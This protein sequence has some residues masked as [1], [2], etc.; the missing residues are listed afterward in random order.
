MVS[1]DHDKIKAEPA[2]RLTEHLIEAQSKRSELQET[3]S[4]LQSELDKL[5]SQS[6]V[7]E[8]QLEELVLE[9]STMLVKLRDRDEEISGKT[10]L[11]EVMR[12]I[13]LGYF[14]SYLPTTIGLTR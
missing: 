10:K 8:K 13:W 7:D 4:V 11:L 6:R 14:D 3:L 9:R 12:C 1:H 2:F 5:R